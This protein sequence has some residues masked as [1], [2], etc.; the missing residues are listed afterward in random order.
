[1]ETKEQLEVMKRLV[2]VK[3]CLIDYAGPLF[4]FGNIDLLLCGQHSTIISATIPREE[5]AILNNR[6][7]DWVNA[8]NSKA[9]TITNILVIRDMDKISIER[10]E[11]LLDILEENQISTECLPENLKIILHA[12]KRCEI[13]PKIKDIVECYEI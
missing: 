9:D 2:V 11:I 10:Q 8:V 1:M 13:N 6:V 4:V 5:F 3:E 7:P 12:N